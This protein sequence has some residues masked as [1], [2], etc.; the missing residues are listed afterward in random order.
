MID[1]HTHILPNVD[2][3]SDSFEKSIEL[4]KQAKEQGVTH[5]ILTPHIITNSSKYIGKEEIEKR[6]NEFVDKI[7]DLGVKVYLGGE[8]FYHDK[9]YQ[10]LVNDQLITVNNSK[11]CIIEFPLKTELDIEEALYNIRAK[12]FR[13]ILAH[14]ERYKSL[15]SSDVK[16]IKENAQIQVNSSSILGSHGKKIKK[17]VFELMRNDLVDYVSSDCHDP[18]KR[19]IN[20]LQ[21]YNIVRKKFGEEYADKVFKKNQQKLINEIDNAE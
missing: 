16:L 11:Y 1:I 21:A 6:F 17:F 2:D 4:L 10:Q 3:G 13:P 15:K 18:K 20:L 9:T 19:N 7:K 14:P 8:I 5:V 12:G